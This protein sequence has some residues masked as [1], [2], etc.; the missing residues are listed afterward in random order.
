MQTGVYLLV[1]VMRCQKWKKNEEKI[2]SKEEI[3]G[4]KI[5]MLKRKQMEETYYLGRKLFEKIINIKKKY[6]ICLPLSKL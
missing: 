4:K 5:S 3:V 6:R 2:L 1:A